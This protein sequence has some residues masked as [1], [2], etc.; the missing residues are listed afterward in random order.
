MIDAVDRI[1]EQWHRERPELDVSSLGIVGRMSR[2]TAALERSM[3]ATFAEHRLQ[4]GWYDVL[5]SLRRSGGACELAPSALLETMMLTSGAIT[6]RIQ[7]M[8]E[9]G[10]VSRRVD[11]ADG[12]GVLVHMTEHG[13][14]TLDAATVDHLANQR[15]LLGGLTTRERSDLER[16]LRRFAAALPDAP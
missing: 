5:A 3:A 10:L 2:I 13:A 9:A 15:R 6:K 8:E 4:A 11:P 14:A 12:R 1:I 7:R 16:L